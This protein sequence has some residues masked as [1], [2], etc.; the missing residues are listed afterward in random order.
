MKTLS[1]I[2]LGTLLLLS[3]IGVSLA[4]RECNDRS[5][6]QGVDIPE[7]SL[8]VKAVRPQYRPPSLPFESSGPPPAALPERVVRRSRSVAQVVKR[9][10]IDSARS[11]LD[12]TIVVLGNDDN[13]DVVLGSSPIESLVITQILPP[14]IDVA[15]TLGLGVTLSV[16]LQPSIVYA[17]LRIGGLVAIPTLEADLKGASIGLGVVKDRLMMSLGYHIAHS[18]GSRRLSVSAHYTL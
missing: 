6:R 11:V 15:P 8:F 4:V 16:G 7:D 9:I 17:P 18:D 13:M 2:G 12:T 5:S 14:W 10:P 1:R 3:A